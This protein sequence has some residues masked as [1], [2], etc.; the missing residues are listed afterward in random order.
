MDKEK[1][2]DILTKTKSILSKIINKYTIVIALFLICMFLGEKHNALQR[3]EYKQK[4][5]ALEKEIEAYKAEIESNKAMLNELKSDNANL[6]KFARENHL[7]KS[8]DEDVYV[9]K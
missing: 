8:P 3:I 9:V 5:N 7:M 2:K 4:I 6:E 1:A